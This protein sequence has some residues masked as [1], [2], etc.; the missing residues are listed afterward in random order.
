MGRRGWKTRGLEV[1]GRNWQLL[2]GTKTENSKLHRTDHVIIPT[3]SD[4]CLIYLYPP[5][6]SI[7]R[8]QLLHKSKA[9]L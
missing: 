3:D 2:Q 9:R 8:E 7:P 5:I 6:S 1:R 4:L